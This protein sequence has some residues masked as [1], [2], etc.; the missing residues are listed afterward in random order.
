MRCTST[1]TFAAEYE[2][3]S[4]QADCRCA[5]SYQHHVAASCFAIQLRFRQ[6]MSL[7]I[8]FNCLLLLRHPRNDFY[9]LSENT[10]TK[11]HHVI[12]AE[13]FTRDSGNISGGGKLCVQGHNS[14]NNCFPKYYSRQ[15]I[16]RPSN[17]IKVN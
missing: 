6:I 14:H 5:S 4:N 8:S 7:N 13:K 3:N 15:N 17:P 12:Y 2:L 1:G 16:N 10:F 11:D 9:L